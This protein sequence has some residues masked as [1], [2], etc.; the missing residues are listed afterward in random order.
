[1]IRATHFSLLSLSLTILDYNTLKSLILK[2]YLFIFIYI[3]LGQTDNIT[4]D[5]NSN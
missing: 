5:S 1:L 2:L 4:F 3:F